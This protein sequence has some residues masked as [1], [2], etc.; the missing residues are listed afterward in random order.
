[1]ALAREYAFVEESNSWIIC[2]IYM[3]SQDVWYTASM[4]ILAEFVDLNELKHA[5]VSIEIALKHV[6]AFM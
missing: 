5:S 3:H 4:R 6:P 1:M 2:S